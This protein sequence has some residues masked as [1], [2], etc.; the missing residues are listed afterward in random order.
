MRLNKNKLVIV[1]NGFDLA[2]GLRTDYRSFID[3]YFCKAF[4]EFCTKKH[5]SDSL[6]DISNKYSGTV[7]SF[8][9]VPTNF[10][11]VLDLVTSDDYQSIKYTSELLRSVTNQ[12]QRNN[13]VDIERYYFRS[14]K[15]DFKITHPGNVAAV[16]ILN[17][18]FDLITEQLKA[19]I[20][21]INAGIEDLPSLE[22]DA[23][24]S[25]LDMLLKR[26]QYGITRFLNFNY[27]ETLTA[28]AYATDDEVIHIHG[29]AADIKNNPIIF[30]YGDESDPTY[31]AIEDSGENVFLKHIKSFGCFNTGNYH[32]LLSFIDSAEFSVY[33]VG[34]SCG[35]SD[36]VLLN[37]I[38]EH[39]NCK[40]IEICYYVKP[41]GRDNFKEITQEISRHFRPQNKNLMRRKVMGK[42]PENIIPQNPRM[43]I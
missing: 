21:T 29:R 36:R 12:F 3:W 13:W 30:G 1:G 18:H 11:E 6:I 33:I 22:F 14:L 7:R 15:S 34:H 4:Q 42:N 2:H 43:G 27:T 40:K 38:F 8:K 32:K 39:Q 35:L 19:Y 25:N 9:Q 41:D 16:T 17:N 28:K 31:Q 10:V 37:E 5:Y 24:S 26:G 23:S 20:Q